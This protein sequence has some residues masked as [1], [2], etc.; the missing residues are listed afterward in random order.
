MTDEANIRGYWYVN[1][2]ARFP[3]FLVGMLLYRVYEWCRSKKL[4]FSTASLLEVGVVCIF[5][6]F[7]H[8]FSGFG[9]ESV[10]VLLLLLDADFVSSVDI[11]FA[12][13]I[14]FPV[15]YPIN[16]WS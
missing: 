15:F 7:L 13:R 9:A 5:L 4:S 3:D 8:D 1:P 11:L 12:E 16:I 6:L 10:S 14:S 2:L